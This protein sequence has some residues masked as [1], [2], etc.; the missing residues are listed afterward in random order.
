MKRY[1]PTFLI[2]SAL[3]SVASAVVVFLGYPYIAYL[4]LGISFLLY[5]KVT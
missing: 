2:A 3:L 1:T 4:L 5:L